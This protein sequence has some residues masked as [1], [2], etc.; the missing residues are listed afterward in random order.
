V[1]IWTKCLT[2]CATI[3]P[4]PILLASRT[5][6]I[7]S[8]SPSQLQA[9]LALVQARTQS[10]APGRTVAIVAVSKTWGPEW[11]KAARALGHSAFGENY[12]Q[13]A[14]VKIDAVADPSIEWHF[15]GSLQSNKA[16]AVAR[17]CHWFHALTRGNVAAALARHRPP[18]QDALN[19]LIQIDISGESSKDGIDV[20]S[21]MHLVDAVQQLPQLRL[22]GVMGMAAPT[23]DS[24]E[25]RRQ[26]ALG[27]HAFDALLRHLGPE[28]GGAFDTLSM[29]MSNDFEDALAEGATMIRI[30]S[31]IF[32]ERSYL[33]KGI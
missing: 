28:A 31:A 14:I 9:N 5:P 8:P 27:R 2:T 3:L 19:V 20:D 26:F 17:Q 6:S 16:K 15:I 11:V 24:G 18:G 23:P 33:E 25:R 10:A 1:P 29:G 4:E 22:R 7:M 21:A 12:V 32:G 30:G 13:E